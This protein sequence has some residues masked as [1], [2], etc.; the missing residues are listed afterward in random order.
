MS[1]IRALTQ[2]L[3][4]TLALFT[5]SVLNAQTLV[6][7]ANTEPDLAGYRV[8]YG[9]S[10]GVYSTQVDVGKQTQFGAQ[11]FDWSKTWY[12]AVQAYNTSGLVSPLSTEVKWTAPT[13]TTFLSV[14]SSGTYPLVANQPNT[15]TAHA[16]KAGS[17][18]EYRF[19]LYKRTGWVLIQDYSTTNTMTWTPQS[20]DEGSPYAV[21]VWARPVGST[22]Q[23]EAWRGTENF[24]VTRPALDITADVDFPTPPANQVTWTARAATASTE[25]LEYKF[26]VMNQ[27]AGTW[28][29]FREYATSN[30]AQWAAPTVGT[31]AV[32]AWAR[33]VG[34]TAQFD[35][36]TTTPFFEVSRTAPTITSLLSDTTFPAA[37]GTRITWTAR[38]KG[39][40]SG[41]LQYQF[42]MYSAKTGWTIAQP[43]G[44]TSTFSWTPHWTADGE[45]AL[46]VWVR[47]NGS[48]ANYEA[49][50]ASGTFVVQRA[51]MTLTTSSLF[52]V[53]P[54]SPVNWVAEVPD[55]TVSFEY[56][57]W[58][59]SAASGAWTQ[60]KPYSTTRT[61]TWVP[62]VNGNYV[63]QAWARQVGTSVS[64]EV[65][66]GT[67]L[68][69]VSQSPAQVKSL[70]TTVP[71]PAAPGTTITWTAG[72]SGG[73]A[74][75]LEY[76][77]LRRDNG[78][79]NVVRDF[80]TSNTYSWT[81]TANDVGEHAVQVVVRSAGATA[82]E[83]NKTTGTFSIQF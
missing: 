54:G 48:T 16:V 9:S 32:Q 34:S 76:Q 31:Y 61:F 2:T 73:T 50:R 30:Q 80:S 44:A 59:Y 58:I 10:P 1:H 38:V 33:R 53:A 8:H 14:T 11:N 70:T 19:Y 51:T 49:W 82:P 74:G 77:F 12:F 4:I 60:A 35:Y 46:Q 17:T 75:P 66:R 56:Q 5:P 26:L 65:Y 21:Q 47:S 52:P 7:D 64:Y 79:W 22:V 18:I 13:T 83:S 37:T 29:V 68:L 78:V 15:W 25:Q 23:Y 62:T 40:M 57:F 71:L 63:I 28:Q 6:W 43:Y 69:E 41:P 42:W 27:A 55:P 20:A 24:A 81:P 36:S 67:N 45:Y 72:A 39:G 3:V